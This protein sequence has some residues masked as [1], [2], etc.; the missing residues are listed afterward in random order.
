MI[1]PKCE[2]EYVKDIKVCPDCEAELIPFEEF[3]GNLV[4]H[5]DWIVLYTCEM[6]YE[7]EMLKSNLEGAD[8]QTL[9][10]NQKDSSFPTDGDL[11]VIKLLVKKTD[12]EIA[13]N[14]VN[15]IQ[16]NNTDKGE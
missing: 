5:S 12:A 4:H 6:A 10:L 14:I 3:E 9:I 8:I 1:C 7:A 16:E 2:Y 13:A 15:D 11:S